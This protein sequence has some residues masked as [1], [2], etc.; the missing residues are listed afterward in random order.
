MKWI[1]LAISFAMLALGHV[2]ADPIS[3]VAD[4]K[5]WKR[6]TDKPAY[7][8][9][10]VATMCAAP[11]P[12]LI[13]DPHRGRFIDVYVNPTGAKEA[14]RAFTA[15]KQG[16]P[17]K[18]V[19]FPEGSIL[20]KVKFAEKPGVFMKN[21]KGD[22]PIELMTVMIKQAKGASLETGDWKFVVMDGAG[23]TVL[24]DKRQEKCWGCHR[25][26]GNDHVS[27]HYEDY[28]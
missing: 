26:M 17:A 24:S 1:A 9:D 4:F 7:M 15:V 8:T 21:Q 14:T 2:P 13:A 5:S 28:R 16:K 23:K 10:Y 25:E 3:S 27:L 19:S 12:E 6:L 18:D 11:S 20:T 22:H